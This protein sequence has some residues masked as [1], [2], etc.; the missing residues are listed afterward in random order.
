MSWGHVLGREVRVTLEPG[1]YPGSPIRHEPGHEALGAD[2][3]C[4][5]R[6]AA[7]ADPE[8]TVDHWEGRVRSAGR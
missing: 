3:S 2:L 6:V 7:R 1:L 4:L 5:H 8:W